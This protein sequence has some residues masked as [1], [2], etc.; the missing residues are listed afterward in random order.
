M[1]SIMMLQ[2]KCYQ[3]LRPITL[4]GM[5]Q[6]ILTLLGMRR[7]MLSLPHLSRPS[8][9]WRGVQKKA[10]GILLLPPSI[11]VPPIPVTH[12]QEIFARYLY[13]FSCACLY[14]RAAARIR[15]VCIQ[16]VC[17]HSLTRVYAPSV[18]VLNVFCLQSC[19]Y[20]RAGARIR[21]V[22][23]QSCL[24]TR[25]NA[26]IRTICIRAPRVCIQSRLSTRTT[27][28]LYTRTGARIR[29]ARPPFALPL[30]HLPLSRTCTLYRFMR[31]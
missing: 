9:R 16:H 12:L 19:L 21:T 27:E 15:T 24:Y 2:Q 22:C 28:R 6:V 5:Q 20:T 11:H 18:Y 23:I 10:G 26:R 25:I 7:L 13:F 8:S 3:H 1:N 17:I 31:Q 4:L 29:T 30:P 14:T